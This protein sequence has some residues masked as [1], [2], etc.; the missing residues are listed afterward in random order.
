VTTAPANGDGGIAA[1]RAVLRWSLRLYRREWRQQV[2]ICILIAAAV[3]ATILAAGLVTGSR[4]PQNAGFGTANQQAQLSGA[5]PH[6]T[7]EIASL[8]HHFG[9]VAV[10]AS[11][12]V[13]TGTV[14]GAL[15]ESLDPHNEFV[16]PLIELASGR[17]PTAK[18]EVA[19]T[20]GLAQL[21]GLHAGDVW[22]VLGRRF[23][24]VGEVRSPTD[25]NATIALVAPGALAE[26]ATVTVLFNATPDQLAS[27][28]PPHAY[29]LTLISSIQSLPPPTFDVGAFIVLVAG[30]FGMLFIGLIA[31]A[32]FTVMGRRRTRAVGIL[33]ALGAAESKVRLVLLMNGFVLGCISM[34]LGGVVGLSAWWLYAPHQQASVGHVVDPAAIP[35][36]LVI[37]ALLLA[38]VTATVA[39]W[40]PAR[41]LAR[42]PVVAALSGR[43]NEPHASRRNAAIGAAILG[44]GVVLTFAGSGKAGGGG[45]SGAGVL[46]VLLGIVLACVGLY[47]I[48]QWV[49]AQLGRVAAH[50]P[51]SMRI[52][53]RDLARYRSRSG[54]ALGA[55]CLAIVMTGVVVVAATARFSDPFDYVGPNLA[56]NVVQ[57]YPPLS[58]TNF[59]KNCIGGSCIVTQ[60]K[61]MTPA[62]ANRVLA[63][64]TRE[65]RRAIGATS[66]LQ[67]DQPNANLVRTTPGRSFNG[68][69]L[70]ATP[71][72]L[73]HYGID[74]SSIHPD[75]MVLSSR[76]TLPGAGGLA[77][78]YGAAN[79]PSFQGGPDTG[80]CPPGYCLPNPVVQAMPQ[81]PSGTSAANT[82]LTMH[83]MRSLHISMSVYGDVLTTA[84][85]LTTAQKNAARTIAT[86]TG[87]SIETA[88]SFASLNEVL[89]WAIALG[90]LVALGVLA[91][92]VGLIRAETASELRVLTAAGA[93][94]RTRRALTGVT[95]ATLGFVGA[96]L[97]IVTAYLLVGSFLA[98]NFSSNLSELT[99]NLPIR[100]V[101]A[102][103]LGLPILAGI[104]GWLFAAREQGGIGRQPLE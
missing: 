90:L 56:S 46:V 23:D 38:P 67:L 31:V 85:T 3:A 72:L 37:T 60:S 92:T 49:V 20:S 100:P 82:V 70:V 79:S 27:F 4:V 34:V 43:P 58:G 103:V 42:M 39:A 36:W 83:A 28:R 73:R 80:P 66:T 102:I 18:D 41:A 21:Y 2:L 9:P 88:N 84:A 87:A 64:T 75:A 54:A 91:M 96:V 44:G 26:P 51:L 62:E 45:G 15:V 104:G 101:G 24:V 99:F 22:R 71:A 29:Y 25:L 74:P 59:V 50:T 10:I 63:Q 81:L 17:Y 13:T 57:V 55:I 12:P 76:P 86:S 97:G 95:A 16:G 7:A 77:L 68:Q 5:D 69:V 47:L 14:Q 30:T 65:I 52:A 8:R 48:S 61:G 53:L 6:L 94:R 35:W 32:G 11:T 78:I 98:N 89:A 33:G 40:R 19:L 93:S 1:R